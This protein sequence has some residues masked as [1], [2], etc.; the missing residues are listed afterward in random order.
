MR[1]QPLLSPE[2]V[3][4]SFE[5]AVR[6]HEVGVCAAAEERAF[7]PDA[8]AEEHFGGIVAG[9]I[10]VGGGCWWG[11]GSRGERGGVRG[12][13]ERAEPDGVLVER[14]G[15]IGVDEGAG[16]G[17]GNG[18]ILDYVEGGVAGAVHCVVHAASVHEL[19][20]C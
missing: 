15:E 7:T 5:L 1:V 2:P 14:W 18:D 12:L 16:L 6:G 3:D 13:E 19:G 8:E 10:G 4:R 9:G 11:D 20:E 17:H